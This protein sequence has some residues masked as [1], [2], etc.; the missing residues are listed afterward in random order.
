MLFTLIAAC[1]RG[2]MCRLRIL[3]CGTDDLSC[4]EI[5]SRSA[6]DRG[7]GS[8]RLCKLSA[9]V[10]SAAVRPG[11]RMLSYRPRPIYPNGPQPFPDQSLGRGELPGDP[12]YLWPTAVIWKRFQLSTGS[13][14]HTDLAGTLLRTGGR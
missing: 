2:K 12:L 13:E 14:L 6:Y 11:V 4:E 9:S 5:D 3:K 7:V 8:R 1:E 10:R